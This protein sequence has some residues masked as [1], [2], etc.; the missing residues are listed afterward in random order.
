M[1]ENACSIRTLSRQHTRGC[2]RASNRPISR[3][4]HSSRRMRPSSIQD[5]DS[6]SASESAFVS[7]Y[8][9]EVSAEEFGVTHRNGHGGVKLTA[10][11]RMQEG[12]KR[13][14]ISTKEV[15]RARHL[16]SHHRHHDPKHHRAKV[17]ACYMSSH[18]RRT[19][20]D[21]IAHL[22]ARARYDDR[23][24]QPSLSQPNPSRRRLSEGHEHKSVWKSFPRKAYT[25]SILT[26]SAITDKHIQ[27]APS[28][29][30]LS[31]PD[32]PLAPPHMCG[33][34]P[35]TSS[36]QSSLTS[37][38]SSF[39]ITIALEDSDIEHSATISQRRHMSDSV[40]ATDPKM[41]PSS[42]RER[43]M[44]S[45][46]LGCMISLPQGIRPPLRSSSSVSITSHSTAGTLRGLRFSKE[47]VDA[48]SVMGGSSLSTSSLSKHSQEHLVQHVGVVGA[49]QG[50]GSAPMVKKVSSRMLS[51]TYLII[52]KEEAARTVQTIAPAPQIRPP[53]PPGLVKSRVT[54]QEIVVPVSAPALAS[55]VT[56][57]V[58][59]LTPPT[60]P[61]T[62][63]V[64]IV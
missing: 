4:K 57:T 56:T 25:A 11:R 44:Y 6:S 37:T 47:P 59:P 8:E 15:Q 12:A 28:D 3:Q 53:A 21:S 33:H 39:Q 38:P 2:D 43:M 1:H 46:G 24:G 18:S 17:S 52:P 29:A 16:C 26:C 50:A 58:T 34:D 13:S 41:K 9:D 7:E 36:S 27:V 48:S 22:R 55:S 32:S 14:L 40:L 5:E 64:R 19:S 20:E 10:N 45:S 54:A 31:S 60:S 62:M 23:C 35:T 63:S 30:H 51:K 42:S 61:P 49:G